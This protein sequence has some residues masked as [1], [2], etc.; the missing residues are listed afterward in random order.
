MGGPRLQADRIEA[1]RQMKADGLA[2]R[3]I[4]EQLGLT[5]HQVLYVRQVYGIGG[6]YRKYHEEDA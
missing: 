5:M 3:V 2:D 4:A 1:V 6:R